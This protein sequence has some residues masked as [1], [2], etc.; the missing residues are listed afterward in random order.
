MPIRSS[1]VTNRQRLESS[2][3]VFIVPA[4]VN[5]QKDI[6][7]GKS[8]GPSQTLL[9]ES[10]E[11]KDLQFSYFTPTTRKLMKNMGYNFINK[12]GLNSG[13]GIWTPIL[14]AYVMEGKSEDYYHKTRSGLGYESLPFMLH[15]GT[16]GESDE[17]SYTSS[18]ESNCWES[19]TS[20]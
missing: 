4:K 11:E 12:E 6:I 1:F 2:Q 20:T 9:E 14:S 19:N 13:K 10:E 8:D 18:S 17:D 15:F 5:G 16:K 7:F 3:E